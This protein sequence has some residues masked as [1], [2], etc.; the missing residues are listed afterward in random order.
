[1]TKKNHRAALKSRDGQR[2]RIRAALSGSA[3]NPPF[4]GLQSR[5]CCCAMSLTITPGSR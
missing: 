4:A 3:R 5:H 2:F 1:M